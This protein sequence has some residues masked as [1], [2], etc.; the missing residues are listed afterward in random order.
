MCVFVVMTVEGYGGV[1]TKGLMEGVGVEKTGGGLMC[2]WSMVLI[3]F[4]WN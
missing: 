1:E 2:V 4:W 3:G